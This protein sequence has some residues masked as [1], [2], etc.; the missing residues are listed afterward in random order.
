EIKRLIASKYSLVYIVTFED[1][2]CESVLKEISKT[3]F[4]TPMKTYSWTVTQGL[5]NGT[6]TIAKTED[7]IQA[8][9][10]VISEKDSAIFI[11]KDLNKQFE[12]HPTLVRKLRDVYQAMKNS[13]KTIFVTSPVIEVPDEITKEVTVL[14][15][16]LP[17]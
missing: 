6:E 14:E 8:L 5:S 13:Y 10:H 4:Q 11:F 17:N 9:N 12:S 7:P 15:F 3:I 16:E 2:R 1:A